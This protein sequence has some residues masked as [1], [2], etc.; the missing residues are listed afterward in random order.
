MQSLT[1]CQLQ[2][3]RPAVQHCALRAARRAAVPPA[4]ALSAEQPEQLRWPQLL[5]AAGAASLLLLGAGDPAQAA[6]RRA[7]P[8]QEAEGRCEI[9][10]LDKF[11]GQC[12][13]WIGGMLYLA[14]TVLLAA[15]CAWAA[16]LTPLCCLESVAPTCLQTPAPP[17]AWRPAV[18]T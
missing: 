17:L 11:A 1:R 3:Q 9:T 10:A 5:V 7:P 4:R 15:A 12:T 6:G 14:V 18:A 13:D 8:V 16:V 2:P